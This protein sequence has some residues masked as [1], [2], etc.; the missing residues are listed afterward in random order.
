[1][2]CLTVPKNAVGESFSL[3]LLSD[4]EKVWMRGCWGGECQ[5][6]PSK[7]SCLTVPKNFVRQ[8]FNVSLISGIETFY[9][10]NG[11]Y[12]DFLTKLFV[13]QC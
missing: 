8:H 11:F 7:T 13:S 12:H 2:I 10:S 3:L 4:I 5:D 6:F 1:M 9:A